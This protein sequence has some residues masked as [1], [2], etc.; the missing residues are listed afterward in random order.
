M[1]TFI[2][3]S[4]SRAGLKNSLSTFHMNRTV[5][6]DFW[7]CEKKTF[8]LMIQSVLLVLLEIRR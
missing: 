1:L 3:R 5:T 6:W 4:M 2:H 8:S 7:C